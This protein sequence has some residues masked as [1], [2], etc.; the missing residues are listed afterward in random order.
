MLCELCKIRDVTRWKRCSTC[1]HRLH[2][3]KTKKEI[4][5]YKNQFWSGYTF[6]NKIKKELEHYIKLDKD[7]IKALNRL[8]YLYTLGYLIDLLSESNKKLYIKFY[9]KVKD[10]LDKLNPFIKQVM[11]KRWY[12]KE[13]ELKNKDVT[14]NVDTLEK[15]N[16]E[17]KIDKE[18]IETL[19]TTLDSIDI[20]VD[21]NFMFE[22]TDEIDEDNLDKV[23]SLYTKYKKEL[24]RLHLQ[25]Q[26]LKK[27]KYRTLIKMLNE[28]EESGYPDKVKKAFYKCLNWYIFYKRNR[29]KPLL[30]L[31]KKCIK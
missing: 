1:S 31:L 26:N 23:I 4:V 18:E 3:A 24:N 15:K 22:I 14:D 16:Q 2:L 21:D 10:I 19:A 6:S 29:I 12:D 13:Q 8:R 9:N 20:Y 5:P 11:I 30:T 28:I 17:I 7:K 27:E 25:E